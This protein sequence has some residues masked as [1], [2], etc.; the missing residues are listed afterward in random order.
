MAVHDVHVDH[1]GSGLFHAPDIFAEAHEIG[2]EDGW[3]DLNHYVLT[4]LM[5]N[6]SIRPAV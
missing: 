6:E 1:L 2:R 4:H 5:L 3:N